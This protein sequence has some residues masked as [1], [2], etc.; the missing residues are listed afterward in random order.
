MSPFDAVLAAVPAEGACGVVRGGEVA[1]EAG[2]VGKS[3]AG[4]GGEAAAAVGDELHPVAGGG[5]VAEVAVGLGEVVDAHL[6]QVG[7]EQVAAGD[8][9][10]AG[11]GGGAVLVLA[12]GEGGEEFDESVGRRLQTVATRPGGRGDGLPHGV[13]DVGPGCVSEPAQLEA[14]VPGQ[15]EA[16]AQA[17]DQQHPAL[18]G[19]AG[20]GPLGAEGCQG[21][22]GGLAPVA[23][24]PAVV[25]GVVGAADGGADQTVQVVGPQPEDVLA[26][27]RP[28]DQPLD[29]CLVRQAGRSGGEGEVESVQQGHRPQDVAFVG[30]EVGQGASDQGAEVV[31]E[32]GRDRLAGAADLQEA[33]HRQVEVEGQA[34][35][36]AGDDLADLTADERLAV[37]GEPAGEVVVAVLG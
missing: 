29:R 15:G 17:T 20:A 14:E 7:G 22:L 16:L 9:G 4:G 28:L 18:A 24:R 36:L 13:A 19:G 10:E 37:A 2:E 23:I 21:A 31:V 1:G 12:A 5:G 33:K 30:G 3:A 25:G 27:E 32:V 6:V 34:V 11:G 8:G 35:G 26:D